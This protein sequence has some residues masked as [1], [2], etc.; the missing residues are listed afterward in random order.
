MNPYWKNAKGLI[1][2]WIFKS[3][4]LKPI[5]VVANTMIIQII[6]DAIISGKSF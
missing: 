6:I 5:I 1:I 4:V 3:V 2:Y